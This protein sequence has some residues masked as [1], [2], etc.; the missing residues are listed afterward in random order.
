MA[1][2]DRCRIDEVGTVR[3][4]DHVKVTGFIGTV[5][6]IRL[7]DEGGVEYLGVYG[8]RNGGFHAVRPERVQWATSRKDIR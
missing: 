5:K 8:G 1:T 2:T 3:V 7:D 6:E 4:G